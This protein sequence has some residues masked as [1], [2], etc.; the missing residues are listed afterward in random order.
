[1]SIV[2]PSYR[3]P[4]DN[5]RDLMHHISINFLWLLHHGIHIVTL[6]SFTPS[7]NLLLS[8]FFFLC[9]FIFSCL[10]HKYEILKTMRNIYRSRTYTLV[11][12][13]KWTS[14]VI[15]KTST[16]NKE[17]KSVFFLSPFCLQTTINQNADEDVSLRNK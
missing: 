5:K 8:A 14:Y 11:M 1:M 15:K 6:L 3:L 13:M 2:F 12:K 17:E 9:S 16:K 7:F 10:L 4:I